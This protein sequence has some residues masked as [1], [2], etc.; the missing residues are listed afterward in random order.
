MKGTEAL[1]VQ[2]AAKRLGSVEAL[3]G[4]DLTV[5]RGEISHFWVT[6]AQ[7][8][9]LGQMHQRRPS[10]RRGRRVGGR[11]TGSSALAP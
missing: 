10:A 6:M 11:A 4:V 9:R 1:R 3:R 7:E 2:G 5:A 8:N